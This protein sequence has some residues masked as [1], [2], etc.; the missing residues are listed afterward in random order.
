QAS[1][2]KDVFDAQNKSLAQFMASVKAAVKVVAEKDKLDLVIPSN[3]VLY[4]KND[5]DITKDVMADMK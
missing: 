4:T 3:D 5:T 2:Q 1:F